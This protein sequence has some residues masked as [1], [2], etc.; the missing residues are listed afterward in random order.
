MNCRLLTISKC[1]KVGTPANV[2]GKNFLST[3]SASRSTTALLG[4]SLNNS[5]TDVG[6]LQTK[7][8]NSPR[9]NFYLTKRTEEIIVNPENAVWDP[10]REFHFRRFSIFDSLGFDFDDEE[11]DEYEARWYSFFGFSLFGVATVFLTW[12]KP[13]KK[14]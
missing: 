8:C 12:Y 4:Q 11:T 9:R 13:N 1:F 6:L 14:G 3:V 7:L 5:H 2:A 10:I